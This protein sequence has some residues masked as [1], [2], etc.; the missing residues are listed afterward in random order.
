M[1]PIYSGKVRELYDISDKHL[2][3]V[4]TD[5]I[6]AFDTI[7][8]MQ[9]KGKG[10]ALNQISNF[11]FQKTQNIVPNHVID[12]NVENMPPFFA[13]GFFR[14][15]T[16]MVEKL[17]MLP[18]EFIV[19]GYLFGSM[20][21]AYTK[22][23]RF[24]GIMLPDFCS[25]AQKLKQPVL[26]PACKRDTGHDEYITM[27]ELASRLGKEM[28]DRI[29]DICLKLYRTCSEYA[30]SRGLILAD[31]KFEFGL[32]KQGEPVLADEIFTPDSSRYW[33]A[34]RYK[35]G[36]SPA[37]FDKQ[38]LRDWLENHKING[39]FQYDKVP[40]D[41]IKQTEKLY[42]ECLIRMTA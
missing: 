7:L 8:P 30:L 13:D 16:V 22:G 41:V 4:T 33:D 38:F 29:T 34:A 40:E 28:A 9:V 42:R 35:T 20:W 19:R 18:F 6:S 15:R 17:D 23:E 26:T 32:N 39:V 11:W 21:K 25:Q 3:I 10:I 12:D 37:S 2:V 31:S 36:V 27:E 5:R 1:K 14:G 24:C